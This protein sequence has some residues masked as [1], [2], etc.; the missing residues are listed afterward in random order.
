MPRHNRVARRPGARV[1]VVIDSIEHTLTE[2]GFIEL[3]EQALNVM[4]ALTAERSR[5]AAAFARHRAADPH[6]TC[7]DCIAY[8]FER[9]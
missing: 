4:Q 1:A 9:G 8:H 7:N 2:T 6:C 5:T 3:M